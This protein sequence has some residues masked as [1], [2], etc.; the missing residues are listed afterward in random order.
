VAAKHIYE[1]LGF[2]EEGCLRHRVFR[3]GEYVDLYSMSLLRDEWRS[4]QA[5][6]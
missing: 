6:A 4:R 3:D 5:S 2:V 1:K